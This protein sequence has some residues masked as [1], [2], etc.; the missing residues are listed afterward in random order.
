MHVTPKSF[1][2]MLPCY[3]DLFAEKKSV[4]GTAQERLRAGVR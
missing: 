1:L 3:C 4:L 2:D